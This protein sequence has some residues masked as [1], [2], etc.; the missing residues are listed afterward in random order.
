MQIKIKTPFFN[1]DFGKE[2]IKF[3]Q[4]NERLSK[5][6]MKMYT[7]VTFLWTVY[8]YVQETKKHP[9]F[10]LSNYIWFINKGMNYNVINGSKE[11]G[12][13]LK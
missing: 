2:V 13:N 11:V 10:W 6:V 5:L 9:Y 12:N 7:D 8:K 4:K 3:R 1:T